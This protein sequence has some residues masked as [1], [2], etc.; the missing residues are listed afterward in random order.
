MRKTFVTA[1]VA[2]L[3][4]LAVVSCGNNLTDQNDDGLVTLSVNTGGTDASRSL[5]TKLAKQEGNYVEVIFQSGGK[6]Y[7]ASGAYN[8]SLKV[9]VPKDT[10][11]SANAIV[12]IGRK[13]DFTLLA[14]GVP[15]TAI[16]VPDVKVIEFTITSLTADVSA[17]GSDFVITETNFPSPAWVTGDFKKGLFYDGDDTSPCFQ[18]PTAQTINPVPA[19]LTINGLASTN[20]NI[21]VNAAPTVTFN[22][23]SDDSDMP[24]IVSGDITVTAPTNSSAIGTGGLVFNFKTGPAGTY[25]RYIITFEIPVVGFSTDVSPGGTTAI[26]WKIRSGTNGDDQPDFVGET[27]LIPDTSVG[28]L[29]GAMVADPSFKG[30]PHRGIALLVKDDPSTTY[31]II[32]NPTPIGP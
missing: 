27:R 16:T 14:A 24:E 17:Q 18:V 7:R 19:K 11:S 20:A 3:A 2:L 29:P 12:L 6:Y 5:T 28:A 10:Y 30:D 32:V 21:I 23:S 4:I 1:F 26:P 13:S 25:G 22:K 9:N 8:V 31:S 15:T